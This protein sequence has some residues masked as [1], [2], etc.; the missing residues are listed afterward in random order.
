MGMKKI[1]IVQLV[2]FLLAGVVLPACAA[3]MP[4]F[5]TNERLPDA[6]VGIYYSTRVEGVAHGPL[7]FTLPSNPYGN[8]TLP[9]GLSLQKNGQIY[10]TPKAAGD[11][12]FVVQ[13]QIAYVQTTKVFKIHVKPFSEDALNQGGSNARIMGSGNDDITGV[14]NGPNGGRV[15]MHE[16]IAFFI[17][18]K[19]FLRESA[20]P[21]KKSALTYKAS[22]YAWLDVLA[23]DLYYY[24]HYLAK[25]GDPLISITDVAGMQVTPG[26]NTY[27]TRIVQDSVGRKGRNTLVVLKKPIMDLSVTDT[28]VM[29]IQNDAMLQATLDSGKP[30]IMRAYADGQEL[31]VAHAFPFNGYAY[32]SGTGGGLYRMPLDGQV[33]QKLTGNKVS[34]FTAGV[35][36]G[37]HVMVFADQS[38]TLYLM[39]LEGGEASP[40]EGLSASALNADDQ[41]IYFANATDNNR[42]YRFKVGLA[43]APERLSEMS[44]KSLYLFHSYLA[45]ED[46]GSKALYIM[47]K[48]GGEAVRLTK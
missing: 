17:D 23:N 4:V 28:L 38:K 44:A 41:Y 12:E 36:D 9:K 3:A 35:M 39:P 24:H 2:T 13:A 42:I 37:S 14:A 21:F 22:G 16:D 8:Y 18:S 32:F 6:M 47:P 40:L 19:N 20:E 26:K 11:Y 10:G 45:F 34:A 48:A 33:A 29:Y 1:T 25:K 43:E 46:A 30:R 31:G 15:T 7:T 5:T 27:V